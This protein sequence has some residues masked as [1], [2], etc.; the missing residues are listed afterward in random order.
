MEPSFFMLIVYIVGVI[1]ASFIGYASLIFYVPPAKQDINKIIP[2]V[3]ITGIFSWIVV[4]FTIISVFLAVLV[5]FGSLLLQQGFEKL[6]NNASEKKDTT[7]DPRFETKKSPKQEEKSVQAPPLQ[8]KA[9]IV[10]K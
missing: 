5:Y 2:V 6:S 1:L 7:I 8:K 3:I 4:A 10:V 9:P